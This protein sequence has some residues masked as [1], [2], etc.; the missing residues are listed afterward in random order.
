MK[1]PRGWGC[2]LLQIYQWI[3]DFLKDWQAW[4]YSS[5]PLRLQNDRQRCH[6]QSEQHVWANGNIV[7]HSFFT[8]YYSLSLDL[9]PSFWLYV[10]TSPHHSFCHSVTC[11]SYSIHTCHSG[12]YS[13]VWT[14]VVHCSLYSIYRIVYVC[15]TNTYLYVPCLECSLS[16]SSD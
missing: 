1:N 14:R 4:W 11:S 16:I 5:K 8:D 12:M 13:S 7:V 10:F 2:L 6:C 15:V 9:C 3:S